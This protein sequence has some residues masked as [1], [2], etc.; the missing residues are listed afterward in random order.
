MAT[1]QLLDLFS[2]DEGATKQSKSQS[3]SSTQAGSGL[4]QVLQDLGELWDESEYDNEFDL[5]NF[6]NTL[7]KWIVK[8]AVIWGISKVT[9]RQGLIQFLL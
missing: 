6:M 1:D 7:K 3:E 4:K 8:R 5:K 2:L 9:F